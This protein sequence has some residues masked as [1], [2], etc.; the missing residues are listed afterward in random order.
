MRGGCRRGSGRRVRV[1]DAA[2]LIL[3]FTETREERLLTCREV[4]REVRYGGAAPFRAAA[5]AEAG[6]E[7]R[8]PGEKFLE[9]VE[10]TAREAGEPGL[11]E[12]DLKLLALALEL[13]EEGADVSV[14]TSDYSVQ[15]LASILG[16]RVEPILHR[17]I[18][19]EVLWE[20][21]C[22][23]CGWSG[24]GGVGAPCPRCGARLKRRPRKP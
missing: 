1:L 11:S 12:A 3:G 2:A 23:S 10:K 8:E 15:N 21:Y 22:P 5:A 17:G 13:R 6:V 18:S 7:V 4:L 24:E 16:L 9:V 19:R 14:A 20:A